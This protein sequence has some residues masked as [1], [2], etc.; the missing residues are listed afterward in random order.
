M[1]SPFAT[2]SCV[3]VYEWKRTGV[4]LRSGDKP[5]GLPIESLEAATI[6]SSLRARIERS[7]SQ[8]RPSA[9]GMAWD[10]LSRNIDW[11]ESARKSSRRGGTGLFSSSADIDIFTYCRP[12]FKRSFWPGS[13]ATMLGCDNPE[14]IPKDSPELSRSDYPQLSYTSPLG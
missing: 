3:D 1:A 5:H 9:Y 10:E 13:F 12:D 7:R 11:S 6:L 14:A 4:I 8:K 2:A